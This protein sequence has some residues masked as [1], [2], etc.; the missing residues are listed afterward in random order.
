MEGFESRRRPRR[1]GLLSWLCRR[2][3]PNSTATY[4]DR[5]ITCQC[6]RTLSVS[7][8][9]RYPCADATTSQRDGQIPRW[10]APLYFR[11]RIRRTSGRSIGSTPP[12]PLSFFVML[13]RAARRSVVS[14]APGSRPSAYVAHNIRSPGLQPALR[15]AT[16][17]LSRDRPTT[18]RPAA[19][20]TTCNKSRVIYASILQS[21]VQRGL[22]GAIVL[23]R[24]RLNPEG[25]HAADAP[26]RRRGDRT[27]DA[28]AAR[29]GHR[30]DN[31]ESNMSSHGQSPAHPVALIYEPEP[32]FLPPNRSSVRESPHG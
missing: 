11:R 21:F 2:A 1:A 30:Y 26:R 19:G 6:H 3:R 32:G 31:K 5:V 14:A 24:L 8:S 29:R 12:L 23:H 27:W 18:A 15:N 13:L 17:D 16:L 25:M 9:K 28:D 22:S 10:L 7:R 20:L 4:R